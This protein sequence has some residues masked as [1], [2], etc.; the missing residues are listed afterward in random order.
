MTDRKSQAFRNLN[1]W[2]KESEADAQLADSPAVM[3]R[4]VI[5]DGTRYSLGWDRDV[6]AMWGV[7]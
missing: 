1:A 2:M 3:A 7:A 4:P 5:T 6:A